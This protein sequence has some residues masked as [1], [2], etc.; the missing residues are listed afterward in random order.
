[1]SA[2]DFGDPPSGPKLIGPT[3]GLGSLTEQVVQL[4]LLLDGLARGGAGMGL[5]REAVVVLGELKP[6]LD[7]TRLDAD[8]ASDILDTVAGLDGPNGLTSPL[9]QGA[10]RS[11]RS[12]HTPSYA[13]TTLAAQLAV[14]PPAGHSSHEEKK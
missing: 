12:A 10:G 14:A 8:D 13:P 2:N 4:L 7:G 5:G 3:V 1:M 9:F 11:K 6:A